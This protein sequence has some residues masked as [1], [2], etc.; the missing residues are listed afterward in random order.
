MAKAKHDWSKLDP[1]IDDL[2]AQG[3]NDTQI[4][5]DLSIGRQTLVDHLRAREAGTPTEHQGTP[6]HVEGRDT[7]L[8][9]PTWYTM[10]HQRIPSLQRYTQSHQKYTRT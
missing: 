6:E 1:L 8:P 3:W 4:A 5:K 7:Q 2:R 10:E 9:F